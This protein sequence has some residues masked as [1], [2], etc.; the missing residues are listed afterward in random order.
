MKKTLL[1]LLASL[2]LVSCPEEAEIMDL[3]H[4]ADMTLPVVLDY[5]LKDNR[6]FVIEFSET[7]DMTEILFSGEVLDPPGLGK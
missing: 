2:F 1:L 5:S 6:I 3:F 7:V 4:S